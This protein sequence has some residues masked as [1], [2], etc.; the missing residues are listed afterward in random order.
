MA[1]H[2]VHRD[3]CL[4]PRATKPTCWPTVPECLWGDPTSPA[5][6]CTELWVPRENASEPQ[7]PQMQE[8]QR[9]HTCSAARLCLWAPWWAGPTVQGAHPCLSW[10]QGRALGDGLAQGS[11]PWKDSQPDVSPLVGSLGWGWT[12]ASV[13]HAPQP[14][15]IIP[16][17]LISFPDKPRVVKSCAQSPTAAVKALYSHRMS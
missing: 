11:S 5:G 16:G 6:H 3:E 7:F 15:P 8:D 17:H 1:W 10:E 9:L 2:R 4:I 12:G 13:L 14:S